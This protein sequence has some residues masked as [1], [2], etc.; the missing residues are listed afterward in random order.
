MGNRNIFKFIKQHL[1]VKHL[2]TRNE[3]GVKMLL[4]MTMILAIL[5]IAYKKLNKVSSIKIAKLKFEIELENEIIKQ[6]VSA[7]VNVAFTKSFLVSF[8]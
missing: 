8:V 1:N 3:S 2:V 4:C 6:I 7:A 5:I